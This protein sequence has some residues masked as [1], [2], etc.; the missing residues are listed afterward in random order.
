MKLQKGFT[1][2]EL[3]IVVAI[4]AI[5]AAIA[6]PAYQDYTVRARVSE[7]LSLASAAKTTVSENAFNGVAL[8]LGYNPPAATS[9]VDGI[10]IDG[11]TGVITVTYAAPIAAAGCTTIEFNPIP[12][13]VSGTIPTDRIEWSCSGNAAGCDNRFRPSNCRG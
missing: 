12:A 6:I 3:M 7:G 10:A 13:L 1:L 5:L 4:I 11:G 8:D 2:I 9:N